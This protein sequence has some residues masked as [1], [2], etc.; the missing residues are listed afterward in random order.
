MK[1]QDGMQNNTGKVFLLA[2]FLMTPT[3]AHPVGFCDDVALGSGECEKVACPNYYESY[4]CAWQGKVVLSEF[5]ELGTLPRQRI[6][7]KHACLKNVNTGKIYLIGKQTVAVPAFAESGARNLVSTIVLERDSLSIVRSPTE[8]TSYTR[9]DGA[10]AGEE[11]IW[12]SDTP[13]K[14]LVWRSGPP[15][16]TRSFSITELHGSGDIEE[17]HVLERGEESLLQRG[18]KS[19]FS[20]VLARSY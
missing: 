8:F 1:Q 14:R 6:F 12:E 15:R 17:S 11:I 9:K 18:Q 19:Y 10:L 7:S 16:T 4:L 20:W 13:K 2:L 5:K 3:Q